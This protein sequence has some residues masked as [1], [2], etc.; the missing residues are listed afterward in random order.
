MI[1]PIKTFQILHNDESNVFRTFDISSLMT[2]NVRNPL[3][4]IS[5]KMAISRDLA[6][7]EDA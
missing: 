5:D 3:N 4:V 1:I 2:F 6:S 7:T